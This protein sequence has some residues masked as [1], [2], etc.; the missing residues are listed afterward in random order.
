[1]LE[2]WQKKELTLI[3]AP[4]SL[5]Y[6]T[7]KEVY[8]SSLPN[9]IGL[10]GLLVANFD[11]I[12]A[13]IPNTIIFIIGILF[14]WAW[15]K[16][17]TTSKSVQRLSALI[18]AWN[19]LSVN[20]ARFFWNPNL[21]IPLS[22][23]FW[24]LI[25]INSI[26]LAGFVIGIIF[27]LHYLGV[28]GGVLYS[29]YFIISRKWRRLLQ[30]VSGALIGAMPVILFELRN[31]FYLSKTF[32]WNLTHAP[33]VFN[34]GEKTNIFRGLANSLLAQL[35]LV[36]A[37]LQYP[38]I[39]SLSDSILTIISLILL[40]LVSRKAW[41]IWQ[42]HQ[43]ARKYILIYL[44]SIVLLNLG[45]ASGYTSYIWGVF[46]IATWLL[47]ETLVSLKSRLII[48]VTILFII[49]GSLTNI[50]TPRHYQNGQLPLRDLE[51]ISQVIADDNPTGRYNVTESITG[52][53]R[54][55]SLRYFLLRDNAVK[56]QD[57]AGYTN[58]DTLYIAAVNGEDTLIG[59]RW[60]FSATPGLVLTDS[61]PI[62]ELVVAKYTRGQE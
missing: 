18:F 2:I 1:M 19:P 7:P 8:F 27:N 13:A 34:F 15:V 41:D 22:A 5:G 62:G 39:M 20:Q 49:G 9:Y 45:G 32:W 26:F 14:Y 6:G 56:P 61:F 59:D 36:H 48:I 46:P 52:D 47:A 53:A 43:S 17:I 44:S 51:S 54:F 23:I 10:T 40:I 33:Q 29:V 57:V 24:Y 21:I 58:L 12:G 31:Q 16:R 3:G 4:L 37:D 42:S 28:I 11:P 35:G 30:F 25:A 55:V 60:E 50:F 38:I